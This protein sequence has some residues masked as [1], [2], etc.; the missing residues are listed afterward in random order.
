MLYKDNLPTTR[1]L[2]LNQLQINIL[3]ATRHMWQG[4]KGIHDEH[5][6]RPDRTQLQMFSMM[7]TIV[8]QRSDHLCN[9]E[10]QGHGTSIS[11]QSTKDIRYTWIHTNTDTDLFKLLDTLQLN[12]HPQNP[13]THNNQLLEG[14][15][16]PSDEALFYVHS[17]KNQLIGSSL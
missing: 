6:H 8:I 16:F 10:P 15:A 1:N 14:K 11:I 17:S 9:P 3:W 12:R 7:D 2:L 4:H 5:K 13:G